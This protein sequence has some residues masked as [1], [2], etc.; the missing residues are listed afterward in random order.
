[1]LDSLGS[2]HLDVTL[3]SCSYRARLQGQYWQPF[4]RRG[5]CDVTYAAQLIIHPELNLADE[6][7]GV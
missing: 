6:Q 4:D 7:L 5:L 2:V 3:E 1:M